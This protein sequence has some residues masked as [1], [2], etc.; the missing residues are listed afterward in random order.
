MKKFMMVFAYFI[1]MAASVNAQSYDDLYY[2]PQPKD[3]K[4]VSFWDKQQLFGLGVTIGSVYKGDKSYF[5][6]GADFILY[7][8]FMGITLSDTSCEEKDDFSLNT[9]FQFGYFF[10]VFKFG[11]KDGL[12][13]NGWDNAILISPL[14]EF[15]QIL[16][17][18]GHHLHEGVRHHNCKVWIDTSY[19]TSG[20]TGY[21]L[22][23]M[24]R[25][26]HGTLMG[27]ITTTSVGLSLGFGI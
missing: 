9:G 4:T 18:D 25:F 14:I 5:Y 12:H 17:V 16:N 15:N 19:T 22:A 27:K 26:T 8:A 23:V 3:P 6:Y 11:K 10:P 20:E 2:K 24:Y 7:G 1:T 13:N 21:G